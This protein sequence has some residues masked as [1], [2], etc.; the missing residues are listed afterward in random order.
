MAIDLNKYKLQ[1]NLDKYK[2]SN[3]GFPK[4]EPPHIKQGFWDS[5]GLGF[6]QAGN[7]GLGAIKGIGSTIASTGS[8]FDKGLGQTAGRV[9]NAVTGRGFT[10]T[11]ADPRVASTVNSALEA[12]NI[13]QR[14]GELGEQ[15]GEFLI[16]TGVASKVGKVAE[17]SKLLANSPKVAKLAGVGARALTD[18]GVNAGITAAQGGSGGDIRNAALISGALSAVGN[19]A[20]SVL[21]NSA[22]KSYSQALGATTKTNKAISDRVVPEL[23]NRNTVAVSRSSLFNK[24]SANL[25]KADEGLQKAYEALPKGTQTNWRSVLDNLQSAKESVMVNGVALDQGKYNALHTLQNDILKAIGGNADDAARATI[26]VESARKARQIL[27]K[28]IAK[29][30]GVFGLTGS[31]TDVLMARK[32]A[33]NSIRS[34]LASEHPNIGA[35]NKEFNFWKNVQDVV[36]STIQRTK[37]QSS[38]TGELAKDTGAIVGAQIKGTVGA[39]VKGGFTFSLLKKAVNSTAW[40]TTSAVTKNNLAKHIANGELVKAGAILN[41]LLGSK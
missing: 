26:S 36:G 29:S 32:I 14:A 35:I 30:N 40:K 39:A 10:P 41:R 25:N 31:E 23:L 21:K 33:A 19:T 22:E 27:D 2:L 4:E 18:A 12:K 38:L 24:A 9:A 17:G 3:N 11:Q 6:K 28:A 16:P 1:N 37:S 13:D 20:S 5:V 8:L 7:A 15:L 34:Q